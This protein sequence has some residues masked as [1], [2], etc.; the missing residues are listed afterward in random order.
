MNGADICSDDP[1]ILGFGSFTCFVS[2]QA[3]ASS[4]EI[5]L[6]YTSS[7]TALCGNNVASNCVLAQDS[8]DS[9]TL[10]GATKDSTTQVTLTGTDFDTSGLTAIAH[11]H[12]AESSSCVIADATSVQCTWDGGVPATQGATRIDLYF[13]HATGY[14]LHAYNPT[15]VTLDN[16][17]TITATSPTCS[18]AGGCDLELTAS[19]LTSLLGADGNSVT[20]CEKECVLN[21]DATKSDSTKATCS[22]PALPTSYSITNFQIEE[23]GVLDGTW[24]AT[25]SSEISKLTDYDNLVD[26]TDTSASCNFGTKFDANYYGVLDEAKIF[27]NLLANVA[28][29]E[30]LLTL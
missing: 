18:F 24:F 2:E 13:R 9:P 4:D 29:F 14:E 27:I 3:I 1:E 23:A 20:V 21:T 16:T 25:E 15:P 8:S 17:V 12:G 6:I 7:D 30:T 22:V 28:E 26:Y 10:S 11:I 19:G 5:R